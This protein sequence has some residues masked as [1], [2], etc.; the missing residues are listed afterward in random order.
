[1]Y[2]NASKALC[3]NLVFSTRSFA[4]CSFKGSFSCHQSPTII[5]RPFS[6]FNRKGKGGSGTTKTDSDLAV[7]LPI[8]EEWTAVTD[9]AS[10]Q[11]YYW[12]EKT[13]ETTHLGAP[14]P[15]HGALAPQQQQQ[16]GG[17]MMSGLGGMVAQGMAF[18]TGSAIAHSVIGS[19]FGGGDHGGDHGGG[20][21]DNG[22]GD[23][24]FDL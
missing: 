3:K 4:A 21:A 16:E 10:G 12:N 18:G 13:N 5:T 19:M 1:M 17:G 15:N 8:K 6:R 23:D 9:K 20:A 7:S 22:G 24:G 11:I 14:N 2:H